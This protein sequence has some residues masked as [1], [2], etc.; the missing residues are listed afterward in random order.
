MA[1]E[2]WEDCGTPDYY[3]DLEKAGFSYLVKLKLLSTVQLENDWTVHL[4]KWLTNSN[5]TN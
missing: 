4:A 1:S 5:L 3:Y 2:A